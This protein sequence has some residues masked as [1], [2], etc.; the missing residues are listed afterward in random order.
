VGAQIP[1]FNLPDQT[2]RVR[3]MKS[4]MGPK[5]LLLAFVRS[6]DW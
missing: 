2:G 6:A 5:G 1:A 3:D 4:L